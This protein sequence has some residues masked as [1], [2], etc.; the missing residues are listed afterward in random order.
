MAG[1][2]D[3]VDAAVARRVRDDLRS[4]PWTAGRW[5]DTRE[6]LTS[7]ASVCDTWLSLRTDLTRQSDWRARWKEAGPPAGQTG[8]AARLKERVEEVVAARSLYEELLALLPQQTEAR[9]AEEVWA[10][11]ASFDVWQPSP[12][13]APLWAAAL[14]AFHTGLAALEAASVSAL[15]ARLTALSDQP[16]LLLNECRQYPQL[17][18]RPSRRGGAGGRAPAGGAPHGGDGGRPQGRVRGRQGRTP[19][20]RTR[21][22]RPQPLPHPPGLGP[23]QLRARLRSIA[24]IVTRVFPGAETERFAVQ[25]R[26]LGERIG[27]MAKTAYGQWAA[28]TTA[29]LADP[30]SP[31]HLSTSGAALMELDL[32]GG[33]ELVVHYSAQL[34]TLL[35]E[36]RLVS[37]LGYR[38]DSGIDAAVKV[39]ERYYRYG[40]KLRQIANFYNAMGEQILPSQ[41]GLLVTEAQAFEAVVKDGSSKGKGWNWERLDDCDRYVERLEAA[42]EALMNRNRRLRAQH[43]ALAGMAVAVVGVDAALWKGK[44]ALMELVGR[45][46]ALLLKEERQHSPAACHKW[47]L[48]WDQQLY[49]ALT[50]HYRA[51]LYSFT[52]QA[53]DIPI[54]LT[55]S[56]RRLTFRPPLEEV[57]SSYYRTIKRYLDLPKSFVGFSEASGALYA[58]I[59]ERNAEGLAFIF[60]QCERVFDEL[61]ALLEEYRPWGALGLVD[62]EEWMEGRLKVVGD[63]ELNFKAVKQR[64]KDAEK[65]PDSVRLGCFSVSLLPFKAALDDQI[66]RFSDALL[67]SLRQSTQAAQ[68]AVDGYLKD[69][70]QRLSQLPS[71]MQEMEAAKRSHSDLQAAKADMAALVAEMQE[72]D[73]LLRAMT[74][75]VS[76][77]LT[78]IRTRWDEFVT[79]SEAYADYLVDQKEKLKDD[80]QRQVTEQGGKIEQFL[81]RWTALKP[82]TDV[83]GELTAALAESMVKEI[84]GW[85]EEWAAMKAQVEQLTSHCQSFDLPSPPSLRRR[86][87]TR[88]SRSTRTAGL[89]SPPT[90]AT[91]SRWAPSSGWP[92]ASSCPPSTT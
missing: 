32:R 58:S 50:L 54:E 51:L 29:A 14:A 41:L 78:A 76:L 66:H 87:S 28:S 63:W 85:K 60:S 33:G 46:R 52:E 77:D 43:V 8:E 34:V 68:Q 37:E 36:C 69:A 19:R 64:R 30:A 80:V 74:S 16:A 45:M 27:A 40:L 70:M 55:F 18:S 31:L 13:T 61:E 90:A 81:S 26:G 72:K 35:R 11:F 47:K 21:R 24:S 53:I 91:W 71:T 5:V 38:V 92:S 2:L 15:K 75:V 3:A 17:L 57:R 83:E 25:T 88:R 65:I 1:L 4:R 10:G 22:P 42:A 23:Q 39:A 59:P 84:D 73:H 49:K 67:L 44:E 62:V 9:G 7:A 20:T 86:P 48:H 79:H 56:R 89:S 12:F 6:A 82:S